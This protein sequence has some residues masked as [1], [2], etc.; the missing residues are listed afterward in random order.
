METTGV[1]ACHLY[2]SD[3]A[4]SYVNT[5]ESSTRAFDVPAW[6]LLCEAST[7]AAGERARDAIETREWRSLGVTVRS[8]AAVYAL[9]ICRIS[10]KEGGHVHED[11]R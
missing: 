10:A 1:V 5:A 4:A 8:D 7:A 6:V 11:L 3:A 9:E 2:A